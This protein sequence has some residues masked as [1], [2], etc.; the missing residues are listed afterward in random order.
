MMVCAMRIFGFT[1]ARV[2]SR[3]GLGRTVSEA[4]YAAAMGCLPKV[5]GKV[6][7]VRQ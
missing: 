1:L 2:G 4:V 5:F 3:Y 6:G 7:R